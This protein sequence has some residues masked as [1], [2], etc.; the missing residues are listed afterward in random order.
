M[1]ANFAPEKVIHPATTGAMSHLKI[2]MAATISCLSRQAAE[3]ACQN[4]ARRNR[5]LAF[6][7]L[8]LKKAP[9]RICVSEARKFSFYVAPKCGESIC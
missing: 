3:P 6:P 2:I 4:K 9:E 5:Y 8:P 7:S 1:P